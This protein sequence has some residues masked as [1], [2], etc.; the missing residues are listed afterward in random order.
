MKEKGLMTLVF[1]IL[2]LLFVGMTPQ[3]A[4]S[5]PAPLTKLPKVV[6]MTT[7]PEGS[8]KYNQAAAFRAVVEQFS[9]MKLRLESSATDLT[10]VGPLALKQAEF[11]ALTG[12]LAA[13]AAKGDAI[14]GKLG[15]TPIRRVW[16]GFPFVG[17]MYSRGDAGFKTIADLKEKRLPQS[18]GAYE[19][20]LNN[21]G[22][23]AFGG[24]TLE[25]VK[26]VTVSGIQAALK[27]P[28][29][30]TLDATQG[31]LFSSAV[32][33]LAASPHGVHWFDMPAS[34]G[35]GWKRQEK[36]TPWA[37]PIKTG[38]AGLKDGQTITGAGYEDG[39]YSTTAV[40]EDIVYAFCLAMYRGIDTYRK[41]DKGLL[42]WTW[43]QAHSAEVMPYVPYHPGAVKFL[44]EKG[45][46][47]AAHEAIQQEGLMAE[48]E[49]LKK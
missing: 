33:E 7:L 37:R 44:K 3:D 43:E 32:V 1:G 24:L 26:I 27:G 10:R 35:E 45:V 25:D 18:P 15:P 29:E 6:S 4:T 41:M 12:G 11:A 9:P 34:D 16:N 17:A 20:S 36:V 23:L 47:T 30:G 19:W 42:K 22:I 39:I 48:K 49:R 14:F 31:S 28:L 13:G 38:A 5:A 40:S 8:A 21:A 46:W 2:L